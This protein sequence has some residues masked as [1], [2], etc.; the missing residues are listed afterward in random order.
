M[1]VQDSL[2]NIYLKKIIKIDFKTRMWVHMKIN[3]FL[4]FE[5]LYHCLLRKYTIF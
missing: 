3:I 5:I 1:D 4:I 2:S